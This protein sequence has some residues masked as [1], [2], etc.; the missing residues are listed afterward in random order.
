MDA[1]ASSRRGSLISLIVI[2]AIAIVYFSTLTNNYTEAEDS[3][4]Y[5][6]LIERGETTD[7]FSRDHL[8]HLALNRGFF[9]VWKALGYSGN[10]ELP[11]R[12]LNVFAGIAGLAVLL[13][14][15]RALEVR[16]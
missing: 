11:A 7:L 10:A 16:R 3:L 15:L 14:L 1:S 5:L 2:A 8:I 4:H 13:A 6:T 9:D 12:V